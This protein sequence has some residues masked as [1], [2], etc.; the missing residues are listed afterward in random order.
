MQTKRENRDIEVENL[1]GN[2]LIAEY[3]VERLK[4]RVSTNLGMHDFNKTSQSLY[5]HNKNW[6]K[7]TIK[8]DRLD[9]DDKN[10]K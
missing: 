5:M 7:V 2:L 1:V 9:L 6:Y 8:V 3:Q 10:S 4:E